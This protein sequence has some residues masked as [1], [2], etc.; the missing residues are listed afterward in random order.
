MF[1][2]WDLKSHRKVGFLIQRSADQLQHGGGIVVLP[3]QCGHHLGKQHIREPLHGKLRGKGVRPDLGILPQNGSQ[4]IQNVL[5]CLLHTP[6][7]VGPLST[8]KKAKKRP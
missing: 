3:Q 5:P 4:A 8:G 7:A 2:I 1:N 6:L